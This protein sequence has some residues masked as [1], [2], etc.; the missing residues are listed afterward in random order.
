M[1]AAK[2]VGLYVDHLMSRRFTDCAV[3]TATQAL[4]RFSAH[5]GQCGIT[6]LRSV[7]EEHVVSFVRALARETS[8]RT[9]KRL[10][11]NTRSAYVSSVRSFY[12]FLEARRLMLVNP[13]RGVRLPARQR[14]PRAVSQADIRRL[15]DV[16]N[17]ATVIG[18]RDR[19]VLELLY[20]T[21]LRLMECVRLD[22][23]DVDLAQGMILVRNGK[24]KKDR[25]VPIPGRAQAALETYIREVRP[26]LT[27]REDDQS[28]FVCRHGTRLGPMSVRIMVRRY[29]LTVGVKLSTHVLRHSYATH[30]LQG[31]ADVRHVQKL[32]GHKDVATTALYTKV[33]MTTLAN[34]LRRCHPRERR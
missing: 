18:Q 17:S 24:G 26:A 23:T 8:A 11:T 22:L 31:G 3:K 15:L 29:G 1:N 9:G 10:S 19:A 2:A 12:A 16:P 25:F 34:V 20:G 14:L 30:L 5:I 6:D 33:D 27:E 7:T 28:F 4:G 13:A 32:L 21:G